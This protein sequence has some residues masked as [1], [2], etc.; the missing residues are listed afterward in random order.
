MK[1]MQAA[2]LIVVAVF[3]MTVSL[4]ADRNISYPVIDKIWFGTV[5]LETYDAEQW[6][7]THYKSLSS[8]VSYASA[9]TSDVNWLE[10]IEINHCNPDNITEGCQRI[11]HHATNYVIVVLDTAN[12]QELWCKVDKALWDSFELNKTADPF[13]CLRF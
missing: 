2:M 3:F 11:L 7:I 12:Q 10:T 8:R 9:Y 4:E 13:I 5:V 6:Q 1:K